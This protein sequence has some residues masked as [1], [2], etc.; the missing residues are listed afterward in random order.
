MAVDVNSAASVFEAGIPHPLF[1]VTL[2]STGGRN[3]YVVT[4]DGQRFL[5]N[6]PAEQAGAAPMNVVLNFTGTAK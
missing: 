2:S 3:G 5:V 4:R 6:A 1:D